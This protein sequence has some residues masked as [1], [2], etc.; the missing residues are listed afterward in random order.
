MFIIYSTI[1]KCLNDSHA[2]D[3]HQLGFTAQLR[4]GNEEN[5]NFQKVRVTETP[6]ILS[7]AHE[8]KKIGPDSEIF[9][10]AKTLKLLL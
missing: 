8:K 5:I 4:Q 10:S 2:N 6:E 9:S 3:T 1:T 7:G